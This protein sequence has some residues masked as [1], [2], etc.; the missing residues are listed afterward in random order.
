[1]P[2][3]ATAL[4]EGGTLFQLY[5]PA[6]ERI[7]LELTREKLRLPME[8]SADGWFRLHVSLAD[9]GTLYSFV[10]PDGLRVPDPASRFQPEGVHGPSEVIA[11]GDYHWRDEQWRGKPWQ[12]MV[13]YELHIGTFT[14][15]G[16]FSAAVAQLDHLCELGVSAVEIMPVG[17]FP[18][19][20][21]W[22]YDGVCLYAPFAGYG[23]PEDFKNF[24]DEA[25]ARGISVILDVVYNHFGPD[26][27]YIQKYYPDLL[28]SHHTTA[29]G[30]AVNYDS[31]N[32]T[33]TR[34]LVLH[35]ALYW[36]EEFHLD[37][38]RFDAVHAII[39]ERRHAHPHG[40]GKPSANSCYGQ[41]A[42]P[43]SRE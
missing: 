35:N 6:A 28:T 25:H 14:Q 12:Q 37:G 2:F 27:N 8:R 41:A 26:G 13:L 9:A 34:E 16:T 42:A 29:W 1:M 22:G 20:R 32:N 38:L 33:Q 43:G 23:R 24:V 4:G 10:L 15:Q 31:E 30:A 17:A 36:V 19:A 5:A 18:G 11:P 7:E 40:A 3:G 39:D 21:G